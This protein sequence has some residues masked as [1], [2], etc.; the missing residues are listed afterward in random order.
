M[1]KLCEASDDEKKAVGIK[2][3]EVACCVSDGDTPCNG[4]F[5]VSINMIMIMFTV[6]CSLNLF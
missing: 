3:C 1:K 2:E 6:L 4:G 5:T